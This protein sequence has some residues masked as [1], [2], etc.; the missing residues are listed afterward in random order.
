MKPKD[1]SPPFPSR[2]DRHVMIEDGVWYVPDMDGVDEAFTFTGWDSLFGTDQPIHL[3]FCSGNGDWIVE[4]AEQQPKKNWVA[5][6]VRFMRVRKIWSKMKNRGLENLFI[7]CGE[8]KGVS[9]RY[10]PAHSLSG[11]YVH[12]PDPWPKR[13]HAKHRLIEPQF[14]EE[15]AR[16]MRAD[17]RATLVTDD[18]DYSA[19]M[20]RE[21][22]ASPAFRSLHPSPYYVAAE[23]QYGPSYFE[24]LWRRLGRTIYHHQFLRCEE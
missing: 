21:M 9:Q 3:E 10:F 8:A 15:L 22:S 19:L 4:Q 11:V 6:E 24:A 7:I 12:F 16:T 23:G 1:L 20:I 17:A 13:R 14:V 2:A 5:V 18:P